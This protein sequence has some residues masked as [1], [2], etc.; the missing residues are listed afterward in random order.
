MQARLFGTT[1]L[2]GKIS[3]IPLDIFIIY[4]ITFVCKIAS[5][6][7][8]VIPQSAKNNDIVIT[9]I[10]TAFTGEIKK[11]SHIQ[12]LATSLVLMDYLSV[13]AKLRLIGLL[14]DDTSKYDTGQSRAE[15]LFVSG[16]L[17]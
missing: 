7:T 1:Q 2:K 16:M 10:Y 3:R 13:T 15:A 12:H 8:C 11:I 9:M 14:Q 6:A 5:S 4:H 17:L